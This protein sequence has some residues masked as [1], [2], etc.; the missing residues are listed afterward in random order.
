MQVVQIDDL[1]HLESVQR[2]W[3]LRV[4]V[5]LGPW[6]RLRRAFGFSRFVFYQREVISS[7]LQYG[8][9]DYE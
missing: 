2:R 9:E 3:I 4:V 1:Q 5:C 7:R 8:L 6:L